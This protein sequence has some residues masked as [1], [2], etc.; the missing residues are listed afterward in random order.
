MQAN[1]FPNLIVTL[2]ARAAPARLASAR[3]ERNVAALSSVIGSFESK[4]KSVP[5]AELGLSQIGRESEVY[6]R[7][8]SFLL[9]RQ[10]QAA[11]SKASTVSKNRILD[12]PQVPLREDSPKLALHLAS[13]VLGLLFGA[14]LVILRGLFSGVFRRENDM[15]GVL[16]IL[17]RSITK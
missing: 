17:K 2:L 5:G 1:T 14:A 10:Q 7:M 6:S 11:I 8:Y 9:E 16:G 4:L 12:Y 3:A 15:R 13:S